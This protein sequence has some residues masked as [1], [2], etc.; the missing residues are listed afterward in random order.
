MY[1]LF[2]VFLLISLATIVGTLYYAY[3]ANKLFWKKIEE[4]KEFMN[5]LKN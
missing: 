1:I 2:I 3:R 4:V 5:I